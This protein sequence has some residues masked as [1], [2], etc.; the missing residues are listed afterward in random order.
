VDLIL[1]LAGVALYA[2]THWLIVA[3]SRLRGIE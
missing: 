2:A 1:I 3:V